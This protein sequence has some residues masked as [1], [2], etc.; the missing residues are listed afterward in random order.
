MI[1]QS[2]SA[3]ILDLACVYDTAVLCTVHRRIER[4]TQSMMRYSCLLVPLSAVAQASTCQTCAEQIRLSDLQ[5]HHAWEDGAKPSGSGKIG[6]T[7]RACRIRA[8]LVHCDFWSKLHE[9]PQL[10]IVGSVRD[11][12]SVRQVRQS[13]TNSTKRR[14]QRSLERHTSTTLVRHINAFTPRPRMFI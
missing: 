14:Q 3:R 1:F 5:G 4:D 11:V 13:D 6:Y 2:N 7:R 12:I 9:R 8:D 10:L